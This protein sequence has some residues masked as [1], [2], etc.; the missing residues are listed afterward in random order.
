MRLRRRP[1]GEIVDVQ[2]DLF[3][4]D[5]PELLADCDVALRAYD[6][7]A[8]EHAEERYGEYVDL[9]DEVRDELERVRDGYA[10][11]LD[12]PTAAEYERAFNDAAR[13]RFARHTLELE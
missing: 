1:F 13:R 3:A 6:K 10:A 7:A 4:R 8:G 11:G 12:E 2:L 9:V 5:H